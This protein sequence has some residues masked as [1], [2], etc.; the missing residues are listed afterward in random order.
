VT[1]LETKRL[2][3]RPPTPE[4]LDA[5]APIFA[6]PEVIR[7]LGGSVRSRGD[8]RD[9]I[10][11]MIRHWQL[12]RVGQFSV[13]RKA[14][15]RI[16]GRVGFLVWDPAVWVNGLRDEVG[17][18]YETELGWALGREYWGQGY[19]TE[20]ALAA[21]DW[22][23]AERDLARLISLINLENHASIRVAEKLGSSP[24]RIVEGPP[25]SG[26]TCVYELER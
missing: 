2:G 24:G 10:D 22:V 18:P 6:D 5:F 4:D 15:E 25:F 23:F 16:L 3:L 14:D 20:A 11:A 8:V 21:R 26:P 12:Y 9:G 7:H 13:V 17:E 1:Q 19:A